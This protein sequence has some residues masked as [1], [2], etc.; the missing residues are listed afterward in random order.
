MM[1]RKITTRGFI[2]I[3]VLILI[4]CDRGSIKGPTSPVEDTSVYLSDVFS[5]RSEIGS[6]GDES[7]ITA[8]VRDD[9]DQLTEGEVVSFSE[10]T[11]LGYISP[12]TDT[13][14]TTG[15]AYSTFTSRDV[16]GTASIQVTAGTDTDTLAIVISQI[17]AVI[18]T[19]YTES[20]EIFASGGFTQLVA[21]VT[22]T[23]GIPL[24]G[25]SVT[26]TELTSLGTLTPDN[27]ST[28]ANG[29]AYSEFSAAGDTG[30]AAI[31]IETG[32]S[33]DT[34]YVNVLPPNYFITATATPT[35]PLADG[36]TQVRIDMQAEDDQLNPIPNLELR[37]TSNN[38][39]ILS[40]R[41]V[42]TG[43]NGEASIIVVAPA[44]TE[45]ITLDVY[46]G[47]SSFNTVAAKPS[48]PIFNA[49]NAISEQSRTHLNTSHSLRVDGLQNSGSP[50]KSKSI[51]SQS[52][53]T[54]STGNNQA[55]QSTAATTADTL[56]ITFS[57]INL[58]L[59]SS[60]DTLLANET[61]AT[62]LTVTALR[63]NGNPIG[64]DY[65]ITLQS[66][67]G[68]FPNGQ[69]SIDLF[70]NS[71]GRATTTYTAGI[72]PGDASIVANIGEISSNII[73]VRLLGRNP[74]LIELSADETDVIG[75]PAT[76]VAVTAT[77]YD[78]TGNTLENALVTFDRPVAG[79]LTE[80]SGT[81]DADGEY[82]TVFQPGIISATDSTVTLTATA[83]ANNV[84]AADGFIG[85][86]KYPK[87]R[88]AMVN[89][90]KGKPP[91]V[92]TVPSSH[93]TITETNALTASTDIL[94]RGISLTTSTPVDQL[95]ADGMSEA[96]IIAQVNET[97]RGF[98]VGNIDVTLQVPDNKGR[99]DRTV[100]TDDAGSAVAT[101]T[102][103]INPGL[104]QVYAEIG[105]GAV[106]DNTTTIRLLE[107]S[108]KSITLSSPDSYLLADGVS[109]FQINGVIIDSLEQPMQ[110]QNVLLRRLNENTSIGDSTLT[111]D[112]NGEFSTLLTS[113][114][115][116]VNSAE[117][118][119][120]IL[121][122]NAYDTL[123]VSIRGLRLSATATDTMI[124]GD[125]NDET[126]VRALV[127]ELGQNTPLEGQTVR[128][129]TTK[130]LI[131]GTAVTDNQGVAT[132]TLTSGLIDN[133]IRDTVIASLGTDFTDTTYV[134][135]V[136][137]A[138]V[139]LQI[140]ATESSILGNG[141]AS[142]DV[143]VTLTDAFGD[144]VTNT[145]VQLSITSPTG[146]STTN[147]NTGETGIATATV[148]SVATM[149]DD[150]L[151]VAAD[152]SNPAAVARM[153]DQRNIVSRDIRR[154]KKN[155]STQR[156]QS[157]DISGLFSRES[158]MT[159]LQSLSD[160]I[161]IGLRGV[162]MRVSS[163]VT[164]L[165]ADGEQTSAV[166][167]HITETTSGVPVTGGTVQF[168]ASNG[169]IDGS[170]TTGG[171]G[172]AE[173][174]YTS[175][176][177][178]G[179]AI[180]TALYGSQIVARD[181][182]TLLASG[183]TDVSLT[184]AS[185]SI[186]GD[187]NTSF[188]GT[189]IVTDA[190]GN[191][192]PGA[193]VTFNSQ[194]NLF[195]DTVVQT[196]AS[197]QAQATLTAP[198][199]TT[200]TADSVIVTVAGTSLRLA[201]AVSYRGVTLSLT[202]SRTT[203]P[204]DGATQGTIALRL[205]ETTSFVP[206]G[207]RTLTI[208]SQEGSVPSTVETGTDGRTNFTYTAGTNTGTDTIRVTSGGGVS[209]TLVFT[210]NDPVI[211][212]VST[213]IGSA[214]IIGDGVSTAQVSASIT[215]QFGDPV[216]DQSVQFSAQNGS[217]PATATTNSSGTAQVP[218][219]A[220]ATPTTFY[221]SIFVS[222]GGFTDTLRIR[223]FGVNMTMT[224]TPDSIL[225]DGNDAAEILVTLKNSTTNNPLILR[226]VS[227]S[228]ENGTIADNAFT[229]SSGNVTVDYTSTSSGTQ[230]WIYA[231]YGNTITDSVQMKVLASGPQ[232]VALDLNA[233]M[234]GTGNRTQ[235]VTATVSDARGNP[236]EGS[237]VQF[238][239]DL[240][241][242]VTASATTDENGEAVATL[243]SLSTSADQ[244]DSIRAT[245]GSLTDVNA[246]TYRGVDLQMTASTNSV[247]AGGPAVTIAG[248][249][250]ET[251]NRTNVRG[252]SLSLSTTLGSL[253]AT[254]TTDS[255]GDFTFQFVPGT[256][257]GT[258]RIIAKQGIGI[259]D[260]VNMEIRGNAPKTISLSPDATALL[261][262]GISTLE[263]PVTL[264]DSL[265]NPMEEETVSFSTT[266]GTLENTNATTVDGAA[267]TTLVA[268]LLTAN[269]T[270]TVTATHVASG[271]S[272]TVDIT[273]RGIEMHLSSTRTS[274]PAN[275]TSQTTVIAQLIE[276]ENNRYV[277]G[278]PIDF[279]TDDGSIVNTATTD[280]SGKA[281]AILTAGSSANNNVQVQAAYRTSL[282]Q[283][284]T[285]EFTQPVPT[286]FSLEASPRQVFVKGASGTQT[287]TITANIA[288]NDSVPLQENINLTFRANKGYMTSSLNSTGNDTVQATVNNG[289]AQVTYHSDSLTTSGVASI[290]ITDGNVQYTE[291]TITILGGEPYQILL[292]IGSRRDLQ[293]G[294]YQAPV[295][296]VVQDL[297][298]NPASG[299][300]LVYFSIDTTSADSTIASIGASAAPEDTSGVTTVLTTYPNTNAGDSIRVNAEIDLPDTTINRREWLQLP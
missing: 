241:A 264:I 83:S 110:N 251:V 126:Q 7:T 193:E 17:V 30:T 15:R 244:E 69:L 60:R 217:I 122:G 265:D 272:N 216:L 22:D 134:W 71:F 253:P 39:S 288:D 34:V 31:K 268:P 256:Q 45:D 258:A 86:V 96:E 6:G 19:A 68:V 262:D 80:R 226:E 300:Y 97:T 16:T 276:V 195:D 153:L 208:T 203:Y 157:V 121:N 210:L 64:N 224:A 41:R 161:Y 101:F 150:S 32:S 192:V 132:A 84:A 259:A 133:T 186:L 116:G 237:Q 115:A 5:D 267:T 49:Q 230:P 181:T 137:P 269:Q 298:S 188:T 152:L 245:V 182:L 242:S 170:A 29:Y 179:Q 205:R 2:F 222:A 56:S 87:A 142:T 178:P 143:S 144:P 180:L 295:S 250:V 102:A 46:V 3:A 119:S 73:Q 23:G 81:T 289:I 279:S 260:T 261:G 212:D 148:T 174:T 37:V 20:A 190:V 159:A 136:D 266:V 229:N 160:S 197:G 57:G 124:L 282:T 158:A 51:R 218:Y 252:M 58:S 52:M 40:S 92:K 293:N 125:G 292:G 27:D 291:P 105:D 175:S 13:T 183:A 215:D 141:L 200:N 139:D 236:V 82:S 232:D 166:T 33:A 106:V 149:Q 63:A 238:S 228:A 167:A 248:K 90:S 231:S 104:A 284:V 109:T 151:Y 199:V 38:A 297:F 67:L 198:V 235:I 74:A 9:Q 135:F 296:A 163:D 201:K 130:G 257:T 75:T 85:P 294:I 18:D 185:S 239:S 62:E 225:G 118:V 191:R 233:S 206:L 43:T 66:E 123:T 196:N 277:P 12:L 25:R 263:I 247:L 194:Q 10:L 255:T 103:S 26:F 131:T 246:V 91:S 145:G 214:T 162:S 202:P 270:A 77:V 287:S 36:V 169:F 271:E 184:L 117:Q 140:S 223:V 4:T 207:N 234:L 8:I 227:F 108:P 128:F 189:A 114:P 283:S 220:P 243:Q 28:N 113:D 50:E 221:D 129:S 240:G 164:T 156:I 285:L 172:R 99:I 88:P 107:N 254:V 165:L 249:A 281:R 204:T 155:K 177:S 65:S 146:T 1:N 78:S 54:G 95:I 112:T 42:T 154:S 14:G 209:E 76:G 278:K 44:S 100:T 173:V 93:G 111:S 286:Y 35:T 24:S 70:P 219:T 168:S 55:V 89:K 187:G 280:S 211:S 120:V 59:A 273:I 53:F 299:D 290:T 98:P 11:D 171:N 79:T 61:S 147:L 127:Q 48:K 275:N 176:T 138:P 21:R 94:V 213:S 72:T 274:L 47:L